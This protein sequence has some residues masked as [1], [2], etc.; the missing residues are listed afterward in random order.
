M[1][2]LWRREHR[3]AVWT[4]GSKGSPTWTCWAISGQPPSLSGPPFPPAA[5]L[6]GT[7]QRHRGSLPPWAQSLPLVPGGLPGRPGP[8]A[9]KLPGEPHLPSLRVTTCNPRRGSRVGRRGWKRRGWRRWRGTHLES[10]ARRQGPR[11][12]LGGS[13]EEEEKGL[14]AAAGTAAQ[15]EVGRE[16]RWGIWGRLARRPWRRA[17]TRLISA[18][19]LSCRALSKPKAFPPAG[20]KEAAR[21]AGGSGGGSPGAARRQPR[22][23]PRARRWRAGDSAPGGGRG[24]GAG[25]RGAGGAYLGTCC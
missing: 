11:E 14:E 2:L 18:S 19:L 16:G 22:R 1:H 25:Q 9:S 5:V 12:E 6:P 17:L 23:P 4:P 10:E 7:A 8:A 20:D 13:P 24:R 15:T 21:E 3:P